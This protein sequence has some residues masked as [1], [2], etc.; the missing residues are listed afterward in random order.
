MSRR[1]EREIIDRIQVS[2]SQ[3]KRYQQKRL[4]ALLVHAMKNVPFYQHHFHS[5]G[6][7]ERDVRY[8]ED[9]SLLPLTSASDLAAGADQFL[10]KGVDKTACVK[11]TQRMSAERPVRVFLS[12]EEN[13]LI[14]LMDQ[15]IEAIHEFGAR[16]TRLDVIPHGEIPAAGGWRDRWRHGR[17]EYVST[18]ETVTEQLR[19]LRETKPNRLY[20]PLWVLTRLANELQKDEPLGFSPTLLLSWGEPLRAADRELLRDS[21][22]SEPTDLYQT[23]E[24]GTI[25]AECPKHDGLHVN[26]DL[27][28]VEILRGDQPAEAGEPGEVVV[29]SLSNLTMPLIRY[30]TGDLASWKKMSHS[31]GEQALVLDAIHGRVE[32]AVRLTGGGY[33][34]TRQIEECLDQ[35]TNIRKYRAYVVEPRRVEIHVIPD[36]LFQDRTE[37][38]LR[39]ECLELFNNQVGIELKVVRELPIL[40]TRRRRSVLRKAP[41]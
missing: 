26:Y 19:V 6:L 3:R 21:F 32:D 1:R 27:Y 37:Q 24:F 7:S 40:E 29:T 22:G 18:R 4:H 39:R 38:L 12:A 30:Q 10:S 2:P 8:L 16:N 15:R 41:Q 9:L 13:D 14:G 5:H 36:T 23:W 11:R 31:S 34:S 28:Y 25:A 33:V 20:A 35:F 17:H